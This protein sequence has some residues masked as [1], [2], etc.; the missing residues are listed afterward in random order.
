MRPEI[1]VISHPREHRIPLCPCSTDFSQHVASHIGG[2]H[3]LA[4]PPFGASVLGECATGHTE[5]RVDRQCS[6]PIFS[7]PPII[8]C[9][10]ST[11]FQSS[12]SGGLPQA[13]RAQRLG[14][15]GARRVRRGRAR[16]QCIPNPGRLQRLTDEDQDSSLRLEGTPH[17]ASGDL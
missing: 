9:A 1:W 3:T 15:D 17:R 11:A 8:E 6:P 4:Q 12:P 10:H 14:R 5:G 7:W 16:L 2:E 13:V